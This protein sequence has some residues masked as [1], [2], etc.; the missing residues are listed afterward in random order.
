GAF[1]HPALGPAREQLASIEDE[2]SQHAGH[3]V[4]ADS[5]LTRVRRDREA[6]AKQYATDLAALDS[7]L[8]S[9]AKRLEPLEKEVAGLRKRAADMHESLRRID[10]KI[11]ATEASLTEANG[12]KLDR[13]QVQAELATHR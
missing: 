9:F 2:R 1:D 12:N 7:E 3:V 11:A 10:A 6:R 8:A 4:A 5:E 13:A